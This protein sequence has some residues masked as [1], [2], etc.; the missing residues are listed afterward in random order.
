M[1]SFRLSMWFI[2][3]LDRGNIQARDSNAIAIILTLEIQLPTTPHTHPGLV[4]KIMFS[5]AKERD[6]MFVIELRV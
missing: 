6:E 2:W 4:P 1:L 5:T 3:P